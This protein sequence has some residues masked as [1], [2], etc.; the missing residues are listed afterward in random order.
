MYSLPSTSQFL[1]PHAAFDGDGEGVGYVPVVATSAG[2]EYL[3]EPGKV[4]R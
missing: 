4:R 3:F 1:G 2:R